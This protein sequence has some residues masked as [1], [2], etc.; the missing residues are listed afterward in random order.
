MAIKKRSATA[1]R[2]AR[3]KERYKDAGLTEIKVWTHPDE[4]PNVREH[5]ANNPKTKRIRKRLKQG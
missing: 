2:T 1:I 3:N 4:A 5:A